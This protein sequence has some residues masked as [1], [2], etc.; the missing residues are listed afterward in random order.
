MSANDGSQAV[1]RASLKHRRSTAIAV[2]FLTL[3]LAF[4]VQLL[5]WSSFSNDDDVPSF[6]AISVTPVTSDSTFVRS[7]RAT[8]PHKH[9]KEF[10][11]HNPTM[12]PCI[13]KVVSPTCGCLGFYVNK[14]STPP[15]IEWHVEPQ[16]TT[17]IAVHFPLPSGLGSR[18]VAFT[19][20]CSDGHGQPV[21]QELLEAHVTVL[22][23]MVFSPSAVR[24]LFT[25]DSPWR[26]EKQVRLIVECVTEAQSRSTKPAI[27][28]R[29]KLSNGA[30]F[31]VVSCRQLGVPMPV[32]DS[33]QLVRSRYAILLR[34]QPPSSGEQQS[35]SGRLV[36]QL[37]VALTGK[38]GKRTSQGHVPLILADPDYLEAPLSIEF[39]N[40]TVGAEAR[41]RI[42]VKSRDG[43]P[44]RIASCRS[45]GLGELRFKY[46]NSRFENQHLINVF[47]HPEKPNAFSGTI[48]VVAAGSRT[49]VALI[50]YHGTGISSHGH[51]AS[52]VP[53]AQ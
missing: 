17:R 35:S 23:E 4:V 32:E 11:L 29:P 3:L 49:R 37:H 6:V 1:L 5:V 41:Q 33:V 47:A 42:L 25:G 15:G 26:K 45:D 22:P 30:G 20:V 8:L 48:H 39:G 44:F 51:P 50:R 24:E 2:L 40:A 31:S 18:R 43:V 19:L 21:L 28:I 13:A 14:R 53:S 34:C 38:D 52:T 10:V 27:D 46:D 7:S 9:V 12:K 16:S 36:Q